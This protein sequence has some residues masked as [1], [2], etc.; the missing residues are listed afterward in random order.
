MMRSELDCDVVFR[1]PHEAN[2][3]DSERQNEV[4]AESPLLVY[5]QGGRLGSK[6]ELS[7]EG[8]VE[9]GGTEKQSLDRKDVL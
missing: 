6:R 9:Y 8:R 7:K 1:L 4:S 2:P 5:R 3:M